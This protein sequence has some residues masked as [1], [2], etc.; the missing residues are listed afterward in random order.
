MRYIAKYVDSRDLRDFYNA[1]TPNITNKK[2][3]GV[4]A[5]YLKVIHLGTK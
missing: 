3:L 5:L 4:Y 2:L 1:Y